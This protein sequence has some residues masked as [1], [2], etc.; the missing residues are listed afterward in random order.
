MSIPVFRFV[1]AS[2]SLLLAMVFASP[3]YAQ[4]S[5]GGDAP[6]AAGGAGQVMPD[7]VD[8]VADPAWQVLEVGQDGI[9][10]L[11]I[12]HTIQDVHAEM[13]QIDATAWVIQTGTQPAV[14][15]RTVYRDSRDEVVHYRL[16]NQDRWIV[17]P[18]APS[19]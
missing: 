10:Y 17:L 5:G 4:V 13:V 15:G 14:T 2:A 11:E 18:V 16:S 7:V 19:R 3:V 1:L 6:R 8:L 12:D 9:R